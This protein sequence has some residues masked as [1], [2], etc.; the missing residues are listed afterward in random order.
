MTLRF[1]N[2]HLNETVIKAARSGKYFIP[3]LP[4][5]FNLPELP[6][7]SFNALC[8][9]VIDLIVAS[10]LAMEF[11]FRIQDESY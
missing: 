1:C 3:F 10:G 8:L 9:L 5:L 6:M 2:K 11:G 7:N 4:F